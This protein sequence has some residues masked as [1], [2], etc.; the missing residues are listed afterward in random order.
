MI[1]LRH[2][3]WNGVFLRD[4]LIEDGDDAE[5]NLL[6][7][8]WSRERFPHTRQVIDAKS[9]EKTRRMQNEILIPPSSVFYCMLPLT[10]T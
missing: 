9:R 8:P 3:L 2:H 5:V 6:Y 1:S 10:L 7:V 4:E